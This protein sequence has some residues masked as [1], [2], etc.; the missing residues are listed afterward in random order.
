[1]TI[2]KQMAYRGVVYGYIGIIK[3]IEQE[4]LTIKT[5]Y[6]DFVPRITF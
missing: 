4:N 2:F 1:M 3:I 6:P 5:K